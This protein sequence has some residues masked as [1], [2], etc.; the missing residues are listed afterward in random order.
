MAIVLP[1]VARYKP[2]MKGVYEVAPALRPIGSDFGNDSQDGC[3]I[4]LDHDFPHYR[5][6]KIAAYADDREKYFGVS[7]LSLP[8]SLAV[9]NAIASCL[10]DDYPAFYSRDARS[11]RCE[12]T[13]EQVEWTIDGRLDRE[14]SHLAIHCTHLLEALAFQ[15]EADLA[16]VVREADGSDRVAAVH[17][18]APSHWDPVSKI[19]QSFFQTHTVVPGFERINTAASRMVD[20]MIRQGPFVRFVWGVESDDRLN[21]HPEP[22]A[23][24]EM[25]TWNG[26][27]F[28]QHPFWV[29]VERQSLIG[30]PDVQ[31]A[32]FV[33]HA[34]TSSGEDV[35]RSSGE[36]RALLSAINSMSPEARRYK[37]LDLHFDSLVR[38]L[39][40]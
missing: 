33:I 25:D 22:P 15:I 7:N 18:C 17:V 9:A 37:G 12:L 28:D 11:L 8:V 32:L 16:V 26:R 4:Q 38:Q 14:R 19:G 13:E 24:W 3:L 23:G 10:A 35:L 29:R 39:T 36:R 6:N 2:W 30:L 1:S 31:A 34:K 20:A 5:V 21:H 40:P 27:R